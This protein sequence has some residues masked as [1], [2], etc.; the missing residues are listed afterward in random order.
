[1]RFVFFTLEETYL[2]AL[3]RATA[4]ARA[5]TGYPFDVTSYPA[6]RLA[7]PAVRAAAATALAQADAIFA[8]MLFFDDHVR[9]VADLL[10][11]VQAAQPHL[12]VLVVNSAPELLERTRLGSLRLDE[13]W[14]ARLVAREGAR[15]GDRSSPEPSAGSDLGRRLLGLSRSLPRLLGRVP[16]VSGDLARYLQALQYWV[17]GTPENLANLLLLLATHYGPAPARRALAGQT[18]APPR[19]MPQAAIF[20]PDAPEPF[21]SLTMYRRWRAAQGRPSGAAAA[22]T[23]GLLALRSSI[24]TGNTAHVAAVVAALE[25]RGLEPI[26]AYAGGLDMRT[27]MRRFFAAPDDPAPADT[28]GVDVLVNLSGFALVGGM[29][30]NEAALAV[31]ELSRLDRPLLTGIPLNF[32]SLAD[33]AAS[34]TGITPVQIAM[35]MAVPELEGAVEPVVYGGVSTSGNP[36]FVPDPANVDRLAGRAARWAHLARKTPA[37]RKV[38]IVLFNFPPNGGAVGSAAYLAVFPSLLRLLHALADAGYTVEVPPDAETLR[39]LIVEGNAPEFGTP[40]NVAAALPVAEYRRLCPWHG[41]I[42]AGG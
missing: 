11:P 5:Q 30:H 33:W 26:P 34:P 21:T 20:H 2:Q 17:H 3:D 31:A 8:S 10:A 23:I 4:L 35:Q 38:G 9:P 32:Q 27:A 40:A 6:N 24:L 13:G 15:R 42:T 7:Q 18:V 41:E 22:G 1:M 36:D 29:A 14:A 16:G 19:V 28:T 12:P 37:A 39:C 25:A